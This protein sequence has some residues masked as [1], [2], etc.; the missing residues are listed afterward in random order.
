MFERGHLDERKSSI[1]KLLVT[2]YVK[3]AQP[4]GSEYL[5][6]RYS[7]GVKPATIRHE[8]AEMSEMGYLRQPHISAGRIPS[9]RGYRFYVDQL[10][11]P[12]AIPPGKARQARNYMDEQRAEIEEIVIQSCRLLAGL[13]Q[14]ASLA[15]RPL[16]ED[17]QIRL[18]SLSRVANNK[19]LLVLLLSNGIVEHRLLDLPHSVSDTD[20]EKLRDTISAQTT[21]KT[22]HELATGQPESRGG[23]PYSEA[24]GAAMA[25]VENIAKSADESEVFVEGTGNILRQPEF[26]DFKRLGKLLDALEERDAL[27]QLLSAALYKPGT[28]ILIGSE[29]PYDALRDASLVTARYSIGNRVC[30]TIG[31]V[32]PTRMNY[33]RA[34]AA[35]DLIAKL[36]SELLTEMSLG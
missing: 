9:D 15:T 13:T 6:L 27:F 26:K 25:G 36:L 2:D 32:G 21:D 24:Y 5:A 18:V 29:N 19:L 12:M 4:V 7:L 20:A 31:V 17:T 30:G 22:L 23:M 11:E 10:M 16:I 35:V 1:L 14:C 8:L 3:T 34:T 33:R 28:T